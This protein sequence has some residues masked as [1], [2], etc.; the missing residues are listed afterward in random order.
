MVMAGTK[1]KNK[2]GAISKKG[3]KEAKFDSSKLVSGNTNKNN[4][5]TV[6]NT[7]KTK[8]PVRLLKNVV[9]SF[10]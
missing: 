3:S 8:Y 9:S 10:L 1:N 2:D 6:K 7:P 4:P 5:I